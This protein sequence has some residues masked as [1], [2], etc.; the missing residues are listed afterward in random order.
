MKLA[1]LWNLLPNDLHLFGPGTRIHR[2]VQRIIDKVKKCPNCGSSQF[3]KNRLRC[4]RGWHWF[5]LDCSLSFRTAVD[6]PVCYKK[7]PN[8]I[9]KGEQK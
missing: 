7:L 9:K 5:C 4:Y 1:R 3:Q 2:L 6:C 8:S